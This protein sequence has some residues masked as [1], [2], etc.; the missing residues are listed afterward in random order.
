MKQGQSTEENLGPMKLIFNYEDVFFSFFYDDIGG[1]IHR[2]REYA[3]NYVYSGEMIL[4]NGKE[5][6]HV[7]KGECVFIP[8]DHHITMYKKPF[9]GE[10][11]CGIFLN[12][13]RSFL[14]EMYSKFERYKV[15]SNTP[16]LESG[17]VKLPK[18]A[19]ITS[20]FASLTPFFDPKVKPQDDF[21]QLKLQE[22]LLAL[23]HIVERSAPTLFDYNEPWKIDIL[24]YMNKNYMYE[25]SMEE[26]A[27][28]TGRS[29]ATFKRDFKKIS[30]LTP[31]KWLIR[32]RLEVAYAMMQEGGKK[33]VDV[34]TSVGF[35]NQSHFSAAFK[36]QYGIAPTAVAAII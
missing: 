2:S 28:Y 26:L 1:C 5:Q 3:M 32:K 25:F 33:I 23:L 11:Y 30:D 22:G 24:D 15:P 20:L 34:Y 21:M 27:H 19:E 14:R 18:T 9:D 6:I 36:K 29:L 8:R 16:K 13:T 7:G 4:E 12:F 17:V 10:R 31:E 35:K